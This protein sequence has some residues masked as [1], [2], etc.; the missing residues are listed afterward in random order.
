[1]RKEI[2][3]AEFDASIARIGVALNMIRQQLH[4][5]EYNRK[6]SQFAADLRP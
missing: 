1:M 5:L 3:Q 4:G 6:A 2:S